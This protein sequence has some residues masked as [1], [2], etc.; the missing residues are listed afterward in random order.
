MITFHYIHPSFYLF[1]L[2]LITHIPHLLPDLSA[3]ILLQFQH[4][5]L[6]I[7]QATLK[8]SCST[9]N[10]KLDFILYAY[11]MLLMVV[12]IKLCYDIRA[13]PD[14]VNESKQVTHLVLTDN[15][16]CTPIS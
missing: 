15:F 8:Y 14:A 12:C 9:R 2:Y 13:V 7:G 11:E 10:T 1:M 16:I 5:H 4:H 6:S 3:L